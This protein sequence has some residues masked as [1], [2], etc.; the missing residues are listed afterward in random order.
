[1]TID[2]VTS[3]SIN[4]ITLQLYSDAACSQQVG[5]DIGI[6]DIAAG[7]QTFTIPADYYNDNTDGLYYKISIDC[8]KS[9]NGT[10]QISK[11]VYSFD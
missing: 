6:S 2:A 7:E 3:T 9:S 1:M 11:L 10:I 8:K 5:E 4:D